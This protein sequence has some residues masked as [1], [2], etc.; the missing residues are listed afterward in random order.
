MSQDFD[1]RRYTFVQS[2]P[3]QHL[4]SFAEAVA[5]GLDAETRSLPCRFLYDEIGSK[6]FEEICDLPEY[7]LTR[8][9]RS[10]LETRADEIAALL[11]MPAVLAE[12]GSGSSA[13]TRF[14]IEAFVRRQGALQYVPVDISPSML[15]DSA[16]RLL[17]TYAELEIHAIADEYRDGLAHMREV[18]EQPKLI[19]WLGSNVGNFS[20]DAAGRFLFDLRNAMSERDRLLVGID[21]RKDRVTLESAYD[22]DAGVTSRFNLNLLARVNRELG[23]NFDLDGFDHRARYR[24]EAGRVEIDLVSRR[25]QWVSIDDLDLQLHFS[26]GEAIHTEDSYKYS[27]AEIDALARAADLRL[28]RRWL[29]ARGDFSLNLLAPNAD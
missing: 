26:A 12:L 29:D 6:L 27:H 8:A 10:I 9:E 17:A 7:Y 22:D 14:L 16:R 15:E 28:D 1:A 3:Q 11:P 5:A 2:D 19:A 20:R 25:D 18:L 21:L 4:E 13:K 23:G 24:E